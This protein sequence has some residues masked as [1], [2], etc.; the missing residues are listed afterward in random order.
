M[1]SIEAC[2]TLKRTLSYWY[3]TFAD[4][5]ANTAA[6]HEDFAN[7]Y[8]AQEKLSVAVATLHQGSGIFQDSPALI[9]ELKKTLET[10]LDEMINKCKA[11]IAKVER[12]A[13][14]R[15]E[16]EHYKTKVTKL[17]NEGLN[18]TKKQDKAESNQQKLANNQKEFR[19]L[20]DEITTLLTKL[21]SDIAAV[22]NA[23]LAAYLQMMANHA[24]GLLHTF[25]AAIAAIPGATVPTE[26]APPST[27]EDTTSVP[28]EVSAPTTEDAPVVPSS[29]TT[30]EVL[31]SEEV[32]SSTS[33]DAPPT[34]AT[35]PETVASSTP[36]VP[37]TDSNP[38]STT[39]AV[40]VTET[41][42]VPETAPV[43]ATPAPT[44]VAAPE[45][46]TETAP[47]SESA[48]ATETT[49]TEEPTPTT[50]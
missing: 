29:S 28:T 16:I 25:G 44:E 42:A 8:P 38:V 33:S 35:V 24:T 14:T 11:S 39:D 26:D 21:D 3:K 19:E 7:L 36:D 22:T 43:E 45:T 2:E 1:V 47:V 4:H 31:P 12:R 37:V 41:P 32:S 15:A 18:D 50:V 40:P 27:V 34:T 23:A 49:P 13:V 46:V 6:L 9:E 10:P 30:T 17:A 48:P 5:N 20:D